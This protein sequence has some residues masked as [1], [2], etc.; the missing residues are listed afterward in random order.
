MD[1]APHRKN[2]GYGPVQTTSVSTYTYCV[3]LCIFVIG[4]RKDAKLDV[5]VECAIRR[6][7]GRQTI[8][9]WGVVTSFDPLKIFGL[10]SY[11]WNG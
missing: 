7:Y 8:S 4:D 5:E 2:P 9:D 6:L 3:A 10:Q 1:L 11:H